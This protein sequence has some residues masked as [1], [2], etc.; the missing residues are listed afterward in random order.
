M[1]NKVLGKIKKLTAMVLAAATLT[2][3][4]VPTMASVKPVVPVKTEMAC[5]SA[6]NATSHS[7]TVK[8]MNKTGIVGSAANVRTKPWVND[9]SEIIGA[10]GAGQKVKVTGLVYKNNAPADWYRIIY[11]GRTAYVSKSFSNIKFTDT[12]DPKPVK[13]TMTVTGVTNYLG[14]R[15]QATTDSKYEIGR[16][17]NG[18][19]VT[20]LNNSNP[21]FYLVRSQSTGIQGYVVARFLQ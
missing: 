6:L 12:P 19:K 16:L 10:V 1:T 3:T 17:Y 8:E 21:T 18:E 11:N 14:I 13:K 9:G 7:F 20:V 2:L 5:M 15:S 4:A